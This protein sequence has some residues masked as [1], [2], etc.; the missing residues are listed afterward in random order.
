[1]SFCGMTVNTELQVGMHLHANKY[2][3]AHP[4]LTDWQSWEKQSRPIYVIQRFLNLV[5]NEDS[6]R[7]L[8]KSPGSQI[9][10]WLTEL[11]A[12]VEGPKDLFVKTYAGI[13]VVPLMDSLGLSKVVFRDCMLECSSM[14]V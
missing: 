14:V 11:E 4:I 6:P 10:P 13:S 1:M 2:N 5:A 9:Q 8:L 7:E 3:G 12:V